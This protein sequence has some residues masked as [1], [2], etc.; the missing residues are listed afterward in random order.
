MKPW[1]VDITKGVKPGLEALVTYKGL[2]NG[3]DFIPA[4]CWGGD[5]NSNGV[6]P[7][8]EMQ[9]R[10]SLQNVAAFPFSALQWSCDLVVCLHVSSSRHEE[11]WKN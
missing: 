10:G 1:V 11:D 9:V 7:V 6:P 2:Y 5:C 3:S 8:I 4:P